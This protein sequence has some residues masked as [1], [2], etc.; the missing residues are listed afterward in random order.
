MSRCI[1]D[2]KAVYYAHAGAG[3]LHLRPILDL[4]QS[5][6]V[7]LFR[8]ITTD[9]ARL[10]K[11]YKGSF[12]GEHGDGIVRA[13]FIPMM[14]G[15]ENYDLLRRIKGYFDPLNIF[16]PGK[17]VDAYPMDKSFRYETDRQEPLISTLMDF[18]DTQ[19]ILRAAEQCNGSGDCRKTH[20]VSG[21]MCPSYQ[22][23]RNEQDTTRARA[24]ALREILTNNSKDNPFDSEELKTV[25][26][27]CLSCKA[28]SRECPSNV[29]MASMKAEF[30]YQYQE[31]HGYSFRSRLFA[32][33][34]LLN[35]WGSKIPALTNWLF[36]NKVTG[37]WIKKITGVA[38]ERRLPL[39]SN[40]NLSKYIKNIE[41]KG[42]NRKD[43][44]LYVDEFTEHL[45][46]EI[47]KDAIDLL[48]GLGYRVHLYFG[49]SGRAQISKGFL[50]QVKKL[51]SKNLDGLYPYVNE[52][53][54]VLGLEPSAILT[55][56]DEY[57]RLGMD[58]EKTN[59]LSD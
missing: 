22:A 3:E 23:T 29:D 51:A 16:N 12:S 55:F 10:T 49:Q 6:D 41:N 46:T 26:D 57:K 58:P 30:L 33:N 21:T 17:I 24:N 2:Q 54:P 47:G 11:K 19:G 35:K 43:V 7:S 40:Y 53:I 52:N 31:T 44:L 45:D 37:N 36:I 27:L 5:K 13:E 4:K 9:V 50:K 48:Q 15:K 59:N 25:L 34:Y 1:Y 14:I 39:V 38:R 28:C 56:R 42:I 32:N 20:K 18:S 8:E